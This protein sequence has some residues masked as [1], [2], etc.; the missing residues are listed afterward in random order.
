M[1]EFAEGWRQ[2]IEYSTKID[3]KSLTEAI[4]GQTHIQKDVIPPSHINNDQSRVQLVGSES[5]NPFADQQIIYSS[6]PM[7][8]SANQYSVNSNLSANYVLLNGNQIIESMNM[9]KNQSD[10]SETNIFKTPNKND[11]IDDGKSPRRKGFPRRRTTPTL[12]KYNFQ[13]T[14]QSRT[15]QYS[16]W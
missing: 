12:K 15:E 3:G 1:K 5:V 7:I 4:N 10:L 8:S 6:T 9:S 14:Y 13:C 11:L 2:G 16:N